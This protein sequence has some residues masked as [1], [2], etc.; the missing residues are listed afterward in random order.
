MWTPTENN[1]TIGN[2]KAHVSEIFYL[3]FLQAR[4]SLQ[5]SSDVCFWAPFPQVPAISKC[6]RGG[7]GINKQS[8]FRLYPDTYNLSSNSLF[9]K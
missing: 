6:V 1:K 7:E 3:D 8:L 2:K 5:R 9:A 4:S